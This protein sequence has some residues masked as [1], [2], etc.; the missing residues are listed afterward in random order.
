M[1]QLDLA[2]PHIYFDTHYENKNNPL[3]THD[4]PDASFDPTTHAQQN[5]LCVNKCTTKLEK[6]FFDKKELIVI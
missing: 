2:V 4:N 1:G 6:E 3:T 5:M